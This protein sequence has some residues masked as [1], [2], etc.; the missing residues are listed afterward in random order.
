MTVQELVER[1]MHEERGGYAVT[2]KEANARHPR[3]NYTQTH[4][5]RV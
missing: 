4:T 1:G 2:V 3:S 5:P